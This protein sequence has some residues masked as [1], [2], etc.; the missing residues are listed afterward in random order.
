MGRQ[1][2]LEEGEAMS[3]DKEF[4]ATVKELVAEWVAASFLV[5][6]EDGKH[7]WE[8]ALLCPFCYDKTYWR[9][10][11]TLPKRCVHCDKRLSIRVPLP[12]KAKD[13]TTEKAK[14][15]ASV[16]D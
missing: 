15:D 11:D 10:T 4:E 5:F 12:E 1:E 6:T 7:K 3:E 16:P 2:G 13:S 14:K 8:Y 9:V